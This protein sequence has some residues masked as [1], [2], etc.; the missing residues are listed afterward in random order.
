MTLDQTIHSRVCSHINNEDPRCAED[1][2]PVSA[3]GAYR[4]STVSCSSRPHVTLEVIAHDLGNPFPYPPRQSL[5]VGRGSDREWG[6][7]SFTRLPWGPEQSWKKPPPVSPR[8]K[9][10]RS[11]CR[12]LT[13]VHVCILSWQDLAMHL[14]LSDCSWRRHHYWMGY[15]ARW[16]LP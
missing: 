7:Y 15:I 16:L 2:L 1:Y 8:S 12:E 11:T 9:V 5:K 13:A 10:P 4:P 14:H 3:H 6:S